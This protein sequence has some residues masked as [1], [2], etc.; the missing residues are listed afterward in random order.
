MKQRSFADLQI[1]RSREL[2]RI[3]GK[4]DKIDVLVDWQSI[5][6]LVSVVDRTRWWCASQKLFKKI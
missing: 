3:S 5:L 1:E 2:S 6:A 4:L